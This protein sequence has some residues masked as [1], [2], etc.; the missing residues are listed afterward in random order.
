[1]QSEIITASLFIV[2]VIAFTIVLVKSIAINKEVLN[3][4]K[5]SNIILNDKTDELIALEK[6]K[7]KIE[8]DKTISKINTKKA[9][10]VKPKEKTRVM[11]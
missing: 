7:I 9:L 10:I 3:S 8:I 2:T 4:Y 5:E 1:M 11:G 6:E